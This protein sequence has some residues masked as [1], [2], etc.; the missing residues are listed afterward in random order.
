MV[1]PKRATSDPV[2]IQKDTDKL[3]RFLGMYCDAHHRHRLREPF[4]FDHPK[5]PAKVPKGPKLCAECVR[6]LRHAIVMRVLCPL[7]PKPKCR[8]CPQHCYRP[9]YK[10]QMETVMKYAGPRSILSWKSK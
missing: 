5:L 9:L 6:L 3:V 8:H 2:E 10:D 1:K 7:D 4:Q